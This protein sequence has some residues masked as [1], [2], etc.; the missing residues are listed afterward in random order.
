MDR[1]ER[2][3]GGFALLTA[4]FATVL[5][6][7]AWQIPVREVDVLFGPRLFPLAVMTVLSVLGVVLAGLI[8]FARA[9]SEQSAAQAG[10]TDYQAMAL[11]LLGLVLFGA[12]VEWAGFIVAAAVLF[13]CVARGFGSRRLAVDG[14]V[15]LVLAAAIFVLFVH[16]LD[17]FLPGGTLYSSVLSGTR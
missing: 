3:A 12:L 13:A 4:F 8:F 9:I 6:F 5:A 1:Q 14:S 16:G 17:L 10:P 11:V 7:F 2:S 15:G